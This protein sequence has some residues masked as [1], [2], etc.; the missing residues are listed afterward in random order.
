MENQNITN[1]ISILVDK[2][3][4]NLNRRYNYLTDSHLI[5]ENE[6]FI[7]DFSILKKLINK[8]PRYTWQ[9][10]QNNIDDLYKRDKNILGVGIKI[11]FKELKANKNQ[12]NPKMY[13]IPRN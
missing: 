3:E 11:L 6:A 12:F 5:K 7:R 1:T 9:I 2:F 10:I 4:E 13:G 8:D